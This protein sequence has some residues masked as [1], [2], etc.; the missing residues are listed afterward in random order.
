MLVTSPPVFASGCD[1]RTGDGLRGFIIRVQR[2]CFQQN[3]GRIGRIRFQAALD[4][5]LGFVFFAAF[6]ESLRVSQI[7]LRRLFLLAHQVVKLGQTHLH[8][9]IF[10]LHFQQ[11][12]Q[13]FHR[14]LCAISFQVRFGDLQE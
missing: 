2:F 7:R 11:T 3:C 14:F 12:V 4:Q 8:A 1:S 6:E 13:H 9:Q 5:F 10:R